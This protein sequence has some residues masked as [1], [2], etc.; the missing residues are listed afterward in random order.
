MACILSMPVTQPPLTGV[1]NMYGLIFTPD[2]PPP[3]RNQAPQA[4]AGPD[5]HL[6]DFDGEGL[7]VVALDGQS[8]HDDGSLINYTWYRTAKA[9]QL[10]QT[11]SG[12]QVRLPLPQ[13]VHTFTL[14]VADDEGAIAADEVVITIQP[15]PPTPPQAR[16]GTDQTLTLE[17]NRPYAAIPLMAGPATMI[18]ALPAT[19]GT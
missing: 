12:P 6:I 18:A 15:K 4:E 2:P 3:P 9:N 11:F 10:E 5:Q 19:L 1:K 16:A 8:S 7:E 14:S 17:A 13:G